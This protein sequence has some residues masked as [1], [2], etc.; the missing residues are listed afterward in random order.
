MEYTIS[1]IKNTN[2]LAVTC[3]T[4]EILPETLALLEDYK[5]ILLTDLFATFTVDEIHKTVLCHNHLTGQSLRTSYKSLTP[6]QPLIW[7]HNLAATCE[8]VQYTEIVHCHEGRAS[9][10]YVYQKSKLLPDKNTLLAKFQFED[11]KIPTS[12]GKL[13]KLS[14]FL[15]LSEFGK[16]KPHFG[17][18]HLVLN[19]KFIINSENWFFVDSFFIDEC[20]LTLDDLNEIFDN[21]LYVFWISATELLF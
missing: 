5:E 4:K 21:E 16:F 2:T 8:I 19:D 13:I 3:D 17:S 12:Y 14:E 9:E 11:T 6:A 20:E 1:Y 15:R 7:L 18:G 10:R